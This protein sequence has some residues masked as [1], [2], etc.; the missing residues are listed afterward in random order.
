MKEASGDVEDRLLSSA[1]TMSGA[2]ER[3]GRSEKGQVVA[4]RNMASLNDSAVLSERSFCE[5]SRIKTT[6]CK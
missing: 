3:K 4:R 1:F 6:R 2:R 5:V